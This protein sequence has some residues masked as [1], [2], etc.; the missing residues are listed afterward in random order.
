MQWIKASDGKYVAEP[1]ELTLPKPGKEVFIRYDNSTQKE[2]GTS[3]NI[4]VLY[5][6]GWPDIEWLDETQPD[7]PPGA[8][9]GKPFE[10][11][12]FPG[13]KGSE[14]S[15][16]NDETELEHLLLKVKDT[17]GF[18]QWL[19]GKNIELS[20]EE[21]KAAIVIFQAGINYAA[22][23][24]H[25]SVD[26]VGFAEWL[27]T[28]AEY[29]PTKA[30]DGTIYW[31]KDP[32]DPDQPEYTTSQ[33]LALYAPSQAGREWQEE[34]FRKLQNDIIDILFDCT[35]TSSGAISLIKHIEEHYHL[36]PKN[37]R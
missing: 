32:F 11:I 24:H 25:G 16:H 37:P 4:T 18:E 2:V 19:K 20:P 35:G 22:A 17:S 8:G 14:I 5:E 15:S 31:S 9:D 13:E 26:A 6:C 10:F 7:S 34:I 12:K 33:L 1:V 21:K 30:G 29:A 3:A 23:S 27:S 28:E 36:T